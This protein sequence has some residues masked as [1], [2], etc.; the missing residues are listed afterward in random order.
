MSNAHEQA[1]L[2]DSGANDSGANDV[3]VQRE[4]EAYFT[5]SQSQLIWARFKKQ[6]AAIG[7]SLGAGCFN[8]LGTVCAIS[9]AV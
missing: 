2:P 4:K 5:A 6:R 9:F 1:A 8:S 3:K 7:G